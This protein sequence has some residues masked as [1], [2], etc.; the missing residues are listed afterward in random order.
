MN[1][2]V[3]HVVPH[4]LHTW[5]DATSGKTQC[6]FAARLHRVASTLTLHDLHEEI[7]ARGHVHQAQVQLQRAR[8]RLGTA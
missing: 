2:F 3:S 7:E 1:L 4:L 5:R 8:T 6:T